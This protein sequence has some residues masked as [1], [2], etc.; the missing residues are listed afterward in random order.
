MTKIAALTPHVAVAPQLNSADF[1]VAAARGFRSVINNRP[2]TEKSVPVL[3]D[4]AA[5]LAADV[6]LAYRYIPC[7]G[8]DV[9]DEAIVDDVADAL[10]ELPGP[11]LMYCKSGTRSALLW[12]QAMA[13]RLG[14]KV[15]IET[16]ERAGYD[17]SIIEDEL[18]EQAAQVALA[19]S[20]AEA[21]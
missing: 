21:A 20:D 13:A 9:T 12:A 18:E 8:L 5:E 17:V 11:V 14:V 4:H 10:A 16:A 6:G 3:S 7:P 2:D 19:L 1:A 15:V